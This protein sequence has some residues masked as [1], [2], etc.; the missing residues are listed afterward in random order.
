MFT[1]PLHGKS[2]RAKVLKQWVVDRKSAGRGGCV[3]EVGV[4]TR[5]VCAP[6]GC[7]HQVCACTR[8][9]RARGVFVHE[10]CSCTRC[11]RARGVCV[12]EV[13]VCTRWVRARGGVR[14]KEAIYVN[15]CGGDS[16]DLEFS[17]ER[18]QHFARLKE[19]TSIFKQ[20]S[21]NVFRF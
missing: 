14:Q 15:Q 16:R 21:G 7:V 10:V 9:V 8:W 4:C 6:G 2:L 5:W 19:L 1:C 18:S 12:H 11:V 3:H 20:R 17:K 13:W